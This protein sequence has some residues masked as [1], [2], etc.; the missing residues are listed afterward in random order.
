VRLHLFVCTRTNVFRFNLL[1]T[2]RAC[3]GKPT[4]IFST[5]W[6]HNTIYWR[7]VPRG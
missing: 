5:G 7:V 3:L 2:T 6:T 1:V 4:W